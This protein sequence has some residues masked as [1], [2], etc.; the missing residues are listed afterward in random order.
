MD[1]LTVDDIQVDGNEISTIS[2]N[3]D[4]RFSAN[5]TGSVR[6]EN[7]GIKNNTIT[8]TETDAVTVFENTNNG[9]IKI[10]GTNGFVLPVGS[11]AQRPAVAYRETGM[12]RYNTD[13]ERVEVFN[14]VQWVSVAGAQAGLSPQ[15][16]EDL[17]IET[18]L[19]LG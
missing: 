12:T 9:Y 8:N 6:F 14:G 10:S 5:G 4:L 18:V 2:T 7:F 1:R 15:D 3:T 19:Y 17:A 11:S 13:D 16:A